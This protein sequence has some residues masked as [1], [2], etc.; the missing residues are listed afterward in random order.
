MVVHSFYIRPKFRVLQMYHCIV[1][2]VEPPKT[3][4]PVTAKKG[5]YWKI[6]RW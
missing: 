2:R 1:S 3:A 6:K 4:A 5:R